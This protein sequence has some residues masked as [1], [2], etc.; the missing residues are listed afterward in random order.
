MVASARSLQPNRRIST[1]SLSFAF[2]F[3][4]WPANHGVYQIGDV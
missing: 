3:P 1:C 4:R 2:G